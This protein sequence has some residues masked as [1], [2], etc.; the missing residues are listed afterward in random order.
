MNEMSR[1]NEIETLVVSCSWC[2][3]RYTTFK[4]NCS[5]CG[6]P[7][8]A[9]PGQDAGMLPPAS[10]R[11]LPAGYMRRQAFRNPLF[12]VG[13]IFSCIGIPFLFI[14]PIIGIFSGLWLF[15]LIGGSLGGIF[16]VLGL[17]MA[18][19]GW[20][21][22]QE[23]WQAYQFGEAVIGKV[24]EVYRDTSVKVNGRSP[25][26]IVYEFTVNDRIYEGSEQSFQYSARQR[27]PGQ[28]LHILYMRD[29]TE[30]NT[31][32]PPVK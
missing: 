21:G 3:T 17:T 26:A 19:F 2:D 25:W 24:V 11:E 16:T 22:M 7:I 28:P 31:V 29:N 8:S 30:H 10:P 15:L 1:T 23:K 12:L 5:N 4:S 20:K 9:P 32:Y 14:F 6:G 13:L 27:K 18:R